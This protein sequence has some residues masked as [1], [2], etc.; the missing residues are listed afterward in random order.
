MSHF[1]YV[2]A[3]VWPSRWIDHDAI[4]ARESKTNIVRVYGL[5]ERRNEREFERTL[6]NELMK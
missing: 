5:K 3:P 1:L 6:F 4:D 2:I